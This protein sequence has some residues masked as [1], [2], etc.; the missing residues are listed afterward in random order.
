MTHDPAILSVP[1]EPVAKPAG[2]VVDLVGARTRVEYF[3]RLPSQGLGWL[4]RA[5]YPCQTHAETPYGT[6][7]F[8][9]GAQT[10]LNPRL[11]HGRVNAVTVTGGPSTPDPRVATREGRV[12]R[13]ISK[14]GQLRQGIVERD[15]KIRRLKE[16]IQRMDEARKKRP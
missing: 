14:M 11:A 12:D 1:R 4:P 3:D 9:D 10:W 16:K 7:A 5:D 6:I 2:F 15:D 8:G 13:L